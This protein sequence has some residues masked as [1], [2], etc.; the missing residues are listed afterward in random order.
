MD[1]LKT[2]TSLGQACGVETKKLSDI[3][4]N[5]PMRITNLQKIKT[6]FGE[7]VLCTC[8]TFATFLPGRFNDVSEGTLEEVNKRSQPLYLVYEGVKN[9][10]CIIRFTE[11]STVTPSADGGD[12]LL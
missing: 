4:P 11:R 2:L 6:T 3:S 1:A 9:K 10:R 7:R 5:T 12:V 8:D